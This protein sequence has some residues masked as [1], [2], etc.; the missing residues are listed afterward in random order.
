MDWPSVAR[1]VSI[2]SWS[3]LSRQSNQG[4][5]EL[6]TLDISSQPS[7]EGDAELVDGFR[8]HL[9]DVELRVAGASSIIQGDIDPRDSCMP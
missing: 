9:S 6:G 5:G 2:T 3:V 7:L 1:P 4:N 8:G